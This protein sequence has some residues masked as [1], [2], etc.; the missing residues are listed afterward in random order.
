MHDS[1]VPGCCCLNDKGNEILFRINI[2]PPLIT[3]AELHGAGLWLGLPGYWTSHQW[4][5]SYEATL[6]PQFTCCQLILKWILLP[7]SLRQQQPD[8]FESNINLCCVVGCVS[9]SV[10]VCSDITLNLYEMLLFFR[11]PQWFA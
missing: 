9:R 7:I 10:A 5:S 4:T 6:K 3:I 8:T 2:S 1:K 11:I